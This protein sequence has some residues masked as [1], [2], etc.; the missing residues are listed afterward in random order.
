MSLTFSATKGGSNPASQT[1]SLRNEV[2][3]IHEIDYEMPWSASSNQAWLS[4]SS[5]SGTLTGGTAQ[6]TTVSVNISG[7]SQGVHT[8]LITIGSSKVSSLSQLHG[9][10]TVSVQLSVFGAS[11][12]GPSQVDP[13]ENGTWTT[14]AT[15]G[16]SP[17]HYQWYYRYPLTLAGVKGNSIQPLKPPPGEWYSFGT[18]SYQVTRADNEDFE[19]KCE[20]IDARPVTVTS[21][22]FYVTVGGALK[23]MTDRH[24]IIEPEKPARLGFQ[25]AFVGVTPNPFNPATTICY[26]LHQSARIDLSVYNMLGQRVTTLVDRVQDVGYYEVRCD[27]S[28]LPSGLYV[29]RLQA[30][31]ALQTRKLLLLR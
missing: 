13:Y 10:M 9:A 31:N 29:C 20:V 15:G 23:S 17:Y 24:G 27:A 1:L 5:S 21:N 22:V 19:L 11:I 8:G 28:F 6:S 18:D 4:I 12:S 16:N 30:G 7:L 3:R 26:G 14:T 25:A 2:W